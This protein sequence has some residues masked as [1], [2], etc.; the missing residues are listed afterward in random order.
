MFEE[1]LLV[2]LSK[3]GLSDSRSMYDDAEYESLEAL[4]AVRLELPLERRAHSSS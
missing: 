4:P 3:L 2:A 1:V